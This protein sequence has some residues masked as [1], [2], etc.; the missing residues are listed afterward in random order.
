MVCFKNLNL[1]TFRIIDA[2]FVEISSSGPWLY[3]GNTVY[4]N[5]ERRALE[6]F[7]KI[8]TLL[9][10]NSVY[11]QWHFK[12]SIKGIVRRKLRWVKSG[13]NQ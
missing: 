13:I 5:L 1:Q 10:L 6:V 9:K 7:D 4:E 3:L 2:N 8:F 11:L 12:N